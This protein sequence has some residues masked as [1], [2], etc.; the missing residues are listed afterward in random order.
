MP[1]TPD[2]F[3]VHRSAATKTTAK[4]TRSRKKQP[5]QPPPEP[6]KVTQVHPKAL[7]VARDLAGHRDVHLV[8]NQDGS[9]EIRNG[10]KE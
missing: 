5:P 9:V 10:H 3:R 6:V 4:T 8:F 7:E 2:E 1:D